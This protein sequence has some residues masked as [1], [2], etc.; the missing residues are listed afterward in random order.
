MSEPNSRTT[1]FDSTPSASS[2]IQHHREIYQ[3]LPITHPNENY[4]YYVMMNFYNLDWER[5]APFL[6]TLYGRN[7]NFE[8]T[9]FFFVLFRSAKK[10]KKKLVINPNLCAY[11]ELR[12]P[13]DRRKVAEKLNNANLTTTNTIQSVLVVHGNDYEFRWEPIYWYSNRGKFDY[14][15]DTWE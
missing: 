14:T 12:T 11:V 9:G 8:S 1:R 3:F 13:I 4:T 10:K 6:S 5:S 7:I 15:R 2:H